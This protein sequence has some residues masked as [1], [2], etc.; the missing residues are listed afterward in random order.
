MVVLPNPPKPVFGADDASPPN[1]V[2]PV[3]AGCPN[4]ALGWLVAGAGVPKPPP[5]NDVA[6]APNP[7]F[8]V[9]AGAVCP[10]SPVAG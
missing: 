9:A 2:L 3:L 1:N 6:L 10:K 5:P 4:N 8:P 7:V